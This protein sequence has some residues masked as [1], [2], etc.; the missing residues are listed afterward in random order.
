MNHHRDKTTAE[1][2][3]CIQ[4]E[5]TKINRRISIPNRV[6]FC[7]DRQLLLQIEQ[8]RA[9]NSRL[10]LSANNL[11]NLRYYALSN[12]PSLIYNRG[13]GQPAH[14]VSLTFTTQYLAE[15][16]QPAINLFRSAIDFEGKVSQQITKSLYQDPSL[17]TQISQA[18]HW[19]VLEIL[20]QLPLKPKS[21][22][23][24]FVVTCFALIVAIACGFI[25]YFVSLTNPF[26]IAIC[27]GLIVLSKLVF[28]TF[29]ATKLKSLVI[30]HLLD[31]YFAKGLYKKKVGLKILCFLTSFN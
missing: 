24:W 29:V 9:D 17:L 5:A 7:L 6:N 28:K 31:G 25:W 26:K 2:D 16:N 23:R 14:S 11:A 4:I 1:L 8:I 10:S 21:W 15:E 20:A 30:Y 13:H 3:A 18:H 12:L 22:Y 19:L 27:F